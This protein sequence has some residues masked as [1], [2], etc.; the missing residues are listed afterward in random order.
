MGVP[1]AESRPMDPPATW[2]EMRM[3]GSMAA[4]M[5]VVHAPPDKPAKWTS[6]PAKRRSWMGRLQLSLLWAKAKLAKD[7]MISEMALARFGMRLS[8]YGNQ[9]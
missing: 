1:F 6:S 5:E 8:T 3:R 9:W 2:T 4:T 7:M